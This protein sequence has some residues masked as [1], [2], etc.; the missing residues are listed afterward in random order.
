MGLD[1]A[2]L[3]ES[4][5]SSRHRVG[6]NAREIVRLRTY[7]E[8]RFRILALSLAFA[9]FVFALHGLYFGSVTELLGA[10]AFILLAIFIKTA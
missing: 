4:Q 1:G 9:A 6:P 3:N 7:M 2:E 10:I 5:S 8:E